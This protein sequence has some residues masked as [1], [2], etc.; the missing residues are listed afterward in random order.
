VA[1]RSLADR[2]ADRLKPHIR[3]WGRIVVDRE[4][5]RFLATLPI[6]SLR[7]VEVS[8]SAHARRGWR[9]YVATEYPAFDLC[10]GETPD[11]RADVVICEQVL[12]HLPDPLMAA[13]N[14]FHMLP[15][16]GH[17]VVSVPFLVK[18]HREPG[19][20]WRFSA[21]GLRLLLGKVGFEVLSTG[22]WGNRLCLL[23]NLWRWCPYVPGMP[24]W[25]SADLPII[26]WAFAR[27]P[28]AAVAEA[29]PATA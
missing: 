5:D 25:R 4:T 26:V 3:F 9:S 11:L 7:A 22:D 6:A 28:V 12:E 19:D 24:L 10:A 27:R 1:K 13:S 20:F 2:L 29:P 17:A 16:G 15:P 14:L 21:D 23:A 18:I 8:G